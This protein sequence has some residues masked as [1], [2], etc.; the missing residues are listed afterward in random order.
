MLCEV[1]GEPTELERF[2]ASELKCV[3][4][5]RYFDK[6]RIYLPVD[7]CETVEKLV[8]DVRFRII[9]FSVYLPLEEVALAD[10]PSKEKTDALLAGWEMIK[11][12]VPEVRSRLENEFRVL[13]GP[14]GQG[15][16]PTSTRN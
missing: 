3:E 11:T 1:T 15:S 13:L 16:D 5:L 8:L 2:K 10:P 14:R 6:H 12:Q 9:K 4:F 7:L